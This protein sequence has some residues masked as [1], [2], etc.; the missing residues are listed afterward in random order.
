VIRGARRSNKNTMPGV[1]DEYMMG[2]EV[3]DFDIYNPKVP[4]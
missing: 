3:T 1:E 4:S 2:D